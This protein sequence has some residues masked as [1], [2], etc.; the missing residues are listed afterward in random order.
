MSHSNQRGQDSDPSFYLHSQVL[1]QL[2]LMRRMTVLISPYNLADSPLRR[3]LLNSSP[4]S[5]GIFSKVFPLGQ[6]HVN[7]A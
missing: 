7:F 6:P 3:F 4:D 2:T 1:H 5:W